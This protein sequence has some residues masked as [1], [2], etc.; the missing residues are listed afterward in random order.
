M[1][2][3]IKIF[4]SHYITSRPAS[5]QSRLSSE[6]YFCLFPCA[7][8]KNR[9]FARTWS[10]GGKLRSVLRFFLMDSNMVDIHSTCLS[11]LVREARPGTKDDRASHVV[12]RS[13]Q[14]IKLLLTSNLK[15]RAAHH[16]LH[17]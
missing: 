11:H 7:R 5:K 14:L 15:L 1:I 2:S 4:C 3:D 17:C 9:I 12:S 8:V 10:R 13:H 16:C 6:Y